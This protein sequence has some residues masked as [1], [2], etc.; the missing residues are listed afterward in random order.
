MRLLGDVSDR[1][2]RRLAHGSTATWN[3]SKVV[4]TFGPSGS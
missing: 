1:T 4:R 3:C 2:V